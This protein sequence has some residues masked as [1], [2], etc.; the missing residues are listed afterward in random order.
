M[1]SHST[2]SE[3]LTTFP[4]GPAQPETLLHRAHGALVRV[5]SQILPWN[6]PDGGGKAGCC[7]AVGRMGT[8]TVVR[9]L[10]LREPYAGGCDIVSG[11][12]AEDFAQYSL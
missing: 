9:D 2:R 5:T 4:R 10:S 8:L 1:A 3:S 7:G 11:E 6:C 12:I